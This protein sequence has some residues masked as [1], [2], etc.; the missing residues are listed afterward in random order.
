LDRTGFSTG[1][2]GKPTRRIR[3]GLMPAKCGSR[4]PVFTTIHN[5]DTRTRCRLTPGF[6]SARGQARHSG[7]PLRFRLTALRC[8]RRRLGSRAH[9]RLW[10][11]VA[12]AQPFARIAPFRRLRSRH[13]RPCRAPTC[14]DSSLHSRLIACTSLPHLRAEPARSK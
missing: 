2:S 4:P 10:R 14:A 1:F 9:G 5:V 8:G 3:S 11:F 6:A 13:R 7:A 12:R